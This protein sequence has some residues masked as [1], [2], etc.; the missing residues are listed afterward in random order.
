MHLRRD[1][2]RPPTSARQ[3]CRPIGYQAADTPG[4]PLIK[5]KAYRAVPHVA[6]IAHSG[7]CQRR[8]DALLPGD[9]ERRYQ[10]LHPA[11]DRF[12]PAARDPEPYRTR[13]CPFPRPGRGPCRDTC[14]QP[15]HLSPF[16]VH[17]P[18]PG[19]CPARPTVAFWMPVTLLSAESWRTLLEE[20]VHRL[21][22]IRTVQHLRLGFN[23][24]VLTLA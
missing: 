23:L 9:W 1:Q 14:D 6:G 16:S 17:R 4:T 12:L 18:D 10:P 15:A 22:H 7:W 13:T 24:Q 3:T 2:P 8:P 19:G 5:H 11:E 20:A 21:L